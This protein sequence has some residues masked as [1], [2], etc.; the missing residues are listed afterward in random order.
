MSVE[1]WEIDSSHSGI[2]FAVRHL[3]IDKVRGQFSRWSGSIQVPDGDWNRAIV[4]VVIDASSIE[5]GIDARD[6]HLRAG[7]YL[8]VKHYP[9]ITFQAQPVGPAADGRRRL[10][11]QLTLKGRTR[12]VA[13]DIEDNGIR[14]DGWGN[15]RA[16][17][18]ARTVLN[19][20]HL[21]LTGNLA[22]DSGGVVIGKRVEV[23]IDVEAV[24]QV[25][26]SV[27]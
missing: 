19:R 10:V 6:A 8:D 2:R 25:V 22:L 4:D 18:L 15:D 21:G 3:L 12:E 11:G 13:L 17:F 26:A 24:R 16:G 14:R 5:T 1:R 9:D 20:R 23:D 7:D 27:A